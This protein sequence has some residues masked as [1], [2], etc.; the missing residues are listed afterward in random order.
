MKYKRLI[1]EQ[2]FTGE[3]ISQVVA[4][5]RPEKEKMVRNYNRY[6][7]DKE[8]GPE[9]FAR[10]TMQMSEF[11][12][13]RGIARIDNKVDH[14]VNNAFDV[15]IIDTKVA[16]FLG[17]PVTYD[18]DKEMKVEEVKHGLFAKIV[19]SLRKSTDESQREQM[20]KLVE[21]YKL[22]NNI[23]SVPHC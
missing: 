19:N 12:A 23:E 22:R 9:I 20:V 5:H 16:Y 3:I 21:M 14:K 17:N 1:D 7:V 18:I 8:T 15:D 4:A 6:I 2:G 11:D 10:E 13:V